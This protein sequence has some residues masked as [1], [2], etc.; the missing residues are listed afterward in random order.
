M[1]IHRSLWNRWDCLKIA[2]FAV[3]DFGANLSFMFALALTNAPSALSLEQI[4]SVYI[5]L[6][7]WML[8]S[9]RFPPLKIVGFCVSIGGNAVVAWSDGADGSKRVEDQLL[10]DAL[11][12][13]PTAICAA[14]YMVGLKKC[15]PDFTF[16]ELFHFF[17]IKALFVLLLAVPVFLI[18][19]F[20][21]FERFG[22]PPTDAAWMLF[23][24][25][26]VCGIG[27]NVTLAWCILEFSPLS[28]RLS[29]LLGLPI[30]FVLNIALGAVFSW[31]R[32][33]GIIV[34]VFGLGMFELSDLRVQQR[35]KHHALNGFSSLETDV[36]KTTTTTT[37]SSFT[38][39]T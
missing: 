13:F 18:A 14:V 10:G 31:L 5:G 1:R 7:S 38:D 15:Y 24:I 32:L 22:L 3:L 8:F 25:S 23:I 2:G 34:V 4:T 6:M 33:V 26:H 16:P 27:F 35:R 21:W 20:T 37:A 17:R 30:A 12:I 9:E 36:T 29:I 39:N 11:V 28:A 19:H